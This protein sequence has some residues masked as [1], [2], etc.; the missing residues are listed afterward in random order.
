ME[1]INSSYIDDL[2]RAC[3]LIKMQAVTTAQFHFPL[4]NLSSVQREDYSSSKK[5]N[6]EIHN[7]ID[8][9]K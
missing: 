7:T 4:E 9:F 1:L 2:I 5:E 3:D 8:S 6:E